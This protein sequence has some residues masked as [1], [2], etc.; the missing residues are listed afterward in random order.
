MVVAQ[1][2]IADSRY[3]V[4]AM[5]TTVLIGRDGKVLAYEVGNGSLKSLDTWKV[6]QEA[7]KP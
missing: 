3:G 1:S 6:L 2:D 4:T 5:P 7:L